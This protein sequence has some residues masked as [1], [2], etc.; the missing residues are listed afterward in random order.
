MT[1]NLFNKLFKYTFLFLVLIELFSLLTYLLPPLNQAA[2]FVV[3]AL[4]LVLSLI[5]L[6]YGL[7]LVL[8]ELFIGGHG[9]LFA[10]DINGA[11]LS[12]RIGLFLVVLA[13]WII[14]KIRNQKSEIRLDKKLL[15]SYFLFLI[16][17][18]YGLINGLANN[19]L[20]NVFFD[21]NAWIFFALTPVFLSVIKNENIIKNI[22]QVLTGATTYLALKTIGVLFLF[23][24]NITGIG[25]LFYQW[26]RDTGVG[27]ITYISGSLFRV[28][29]QSQLYCLI[30]FFVV[31]ALLLYNFKLKD[32]KN[33]LGPAI[34]L[35]LVSLAIIISQSRSF[36][37]GGL[38]AL[39]IL[40]IF[41]VWRFGFRIKKTAVLVMIL[42]V[43]IID[44]LFF[45]KIITN[46]FS[47]NLVADRFA[48]LQTEAAGQSRL[49]Q[50]KP[51]AESIFQQMIFGYGFGKTLTYQ[52][53]DPRIVKA[54]PGGIYTTYAFE[55]GYLDIWLKIGLF[56]LMVYLALI[57]MLYYRGIM[58]YESGIKGLNIGLLVGLTALVVT[59]IFSPYL[60]HP[61]GIGYIMLATA[62]LKSQP[63]K[64]KSQ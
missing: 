35:Y 32:W 33:Y 57:G 47:G 38:A 11:N 48:N 44:Q 13:V 56:G 6:E 21:A 23:S 28:F 24:H 61:L 25:G 55:W 60:N 39:A 27:E 4:A 2:F 53:N 9:Y 62:I 1:D 43:M 46:D 3:L 5:K 15:I 29:F 59:N 64:G 49:N 37:V 54:Y 31:L 51:L 10:F 18:L 58:N 34:Y 8:A 45:I 63:T 19:Q 20:S 12:I 17:V 50:L 16:S 7:Y 42:A 26:L 30:G 52:S 22:L 40:L 36:W 14:K 41:A